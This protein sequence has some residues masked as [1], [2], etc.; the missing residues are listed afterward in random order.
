MS[1]RSTRK[2]GR[3]WP[4]SFASRL[5][6][7][8]F[9]LVELLVVI[10]IIVV[11]AS[12]LLPSLATA[13]DSAKA[14]ACLSNVRQI[15]QAFI[16]YAMDNQGYTP[17]QS[18]PCVN[19]FANPAVYRDGK[20]S[21]VSC[22]GLL[23]RYIGGTTSVYICPVATDVTWTLQQGQTVFSDTNYMA[24]Q[25]TLGRALT[26]IHNAAEVAFLQEDR[27][28]WQAAWL[29]P[30]Q[31]GGIANTSS[32]TYCDWC[33]DNGPSWGQE[34]SYLHQRGG[35]LAFV[36]G[37]AEWRAASTIHP[38]TF[39]LAGIPGSSNGNDP[40]SVGQGQTYVEAVN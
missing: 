9:T 4:R 8:A 11:L 12:I 17:Y 13:R 28:R 3:N 30:C 5:Y 23:M 1:R 39:G 34:Y 25:L 16:A 22:L 36:D 29:R 21:D 40:D 35:N 32:A 6:P 15:S 2:S 38:T 33:F 10:G 27:F 14:T 37:H 24:N 31:N 7:K 20:L 26:R 18:N 19:D